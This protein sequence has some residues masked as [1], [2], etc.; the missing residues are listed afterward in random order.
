MTHDNDSWRPRR[1]PLIGRDGYHNFGGIDGKDWGVWKAPGSSKQCTWSLR[2]TDPYGPAT[3]LR[4]GTGEPGQPVR[5]AINPPG[6]ISSI[7]GTVK[8][9]GGR[10]VFQSFGCGTWKHE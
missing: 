3:V 6:D 4:E 9:T 10:V 8:A 1:K 5:V 2:L 7:T